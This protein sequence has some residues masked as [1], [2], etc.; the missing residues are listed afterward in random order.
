MEPL[1]GLASIVAIKCWRSCLRG[2]IRE[3]TR[4]LGFGLP[5]SEIARR[6]SR[7]LT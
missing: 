6:E 5:A 2:V 4:R 7:D 3:R 1:F